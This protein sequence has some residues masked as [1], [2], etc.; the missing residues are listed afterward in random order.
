[1]PP[2]EANGN[3]CV[4]ITYI[5]MMVNIE[6]NICVGSGKTAILNLAEMGGTSEP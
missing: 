1:M 2:T 3:I 4:Y 6:V 5:N